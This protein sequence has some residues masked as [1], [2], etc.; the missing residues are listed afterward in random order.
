MKAI[1]LIK[2]A[3]GHKWGRRAI[4]TVGVVLLLWTPVQCDGPYKGRVV[5]K[6][7]GNPI[8]GVVV[9]ASWSTK[10]FNFA[11]GTTRCIDAA[12]AVTDE[13]GEFEISGR[14]AALFGTLG[15]MRVAIYKVGYQ[16]VTCT[17]KYIGKAS[18]CYEEPVEFDDGWAVFP[19]KRVSKHRLHTEEGNY[20]SVCG[21]KDGKPLSALE[22]ARKEYRR[23]LGLKP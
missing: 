3:W 5:E 10:S 6:S 17:W 15:T 4:I 23:A 19:L 22:E 14:S 12:E 20:P 13:K 21:R 9:V 8:K 2:S 16:K 1:K 11:G 7:T 18:S